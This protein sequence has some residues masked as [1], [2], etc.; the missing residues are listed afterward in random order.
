MKTFI[1]FLVLLLCIS[2]I[3]SVKETFK[4]TSSQQFGANVVKA[5]GMAENGL[6]KISYNVHPTDPSL[7][8]QSYVVIVLLD[9]AQQV[10]WYSDLDGS[11]SLISNNI[12]SL[13]NQPS[14]K[15]I[16]AVG[17]GKVNFTI[18]QSV[19]SNRFTVAVLQ[20]RAG[21]TNNPVAVSLKLHM[22]NARPSGDGYS[23]LPIQYAMLTRFYEGLVIM[24]CLMLVGILSQFYFAT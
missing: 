14:L 19:G 17:E 5:F 20:C 22:L 24:Y 16:H 10:N 1:L 15:R 13:C 11:E 7:P 12:G 4:K 6:I 9:E 2:N 21:Y 8:Y 23:H 3:S 18:S